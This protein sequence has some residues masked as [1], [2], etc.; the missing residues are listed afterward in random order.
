MITAKKIL[1]DY[2]EAKGGAKEYAPIVDLHIDSVKALLNK[3]GVGAKVV[4][5]IL[6]ESGFLFEKAFEVGE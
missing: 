3:E 1:I 4:E 6:T 5:N 2:I